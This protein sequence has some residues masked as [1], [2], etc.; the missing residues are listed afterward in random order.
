MRHVKWLSIVFLLFNK[1]S[2]AGTV[3]V[4]CY[5][6]SQCTVSCN[7]GIICQYIL[8]I[9]HSDSPRVIV[10]MYHL[11]STPESF[12][13]NKNSI[14][15][16]LFIHYQSTLFFNLIVEYQSEIYWVFI[17]RYFETSPSEPPFLKFYLDIFNQVPSPKSISLN[18]GS[19]LPVVWFRK[20]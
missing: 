19:Y 8:S 10:I 7:D 15:F 1:P 2:P 16:G 18:M 17:I 11:V 20:I 3:K 12:K 14:Y 13:I 6:F 5:G 9:T 4:N